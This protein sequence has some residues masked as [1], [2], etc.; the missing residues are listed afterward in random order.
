MA[1]YKETI[2]RFIIDGGHPGEAGFSA[3]GD[4][5]DITDYTPA[6]MRTFETKT[7][8]SGEMNLQS[9]WGWVISA[10]M[11]IF[12]S[13]GDMVG[14]I[15]CDFEAESVYQAVY[16][17]ILQQVIFVVVFMVIG[18]ILY[19]SLLK[20]ITRQNQKLIDMNKAFQAAS[21]SKS[22]FLARM[23]HEIRTP[24]NAIIGMNELAIRDYGHSEALEC[25]YDIRQAG[26]TLLSIIND[27]LDFSKIESGHIQ[28]TTARYDTAS[29]LNDALAIIRIRLCDKP[30]ELTA[31]ID[32][33]IPAFMTGDEVRVRQILLNILSNAEKY[34]NEGF[35]KF[36]ARW[37]KIG[38]ETVSLSFSVEDSGIGIKREDIGR[39][40]GDFSRVDL[41]RNKNIHD[42]QCFAVFGSSPDVS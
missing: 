36:T 12:N 31:D 20:A 17:R 35:I 9:S 4:E 30:I 1:P 3:L 25:L 34:T 23:S 7:V 13:A 24:M 42:G 38:D 33:S 2:H 28:I 15:G 27:I 6:Y 11:P 40:F 18:S 16:A 8:Q 21:E 37:E 5:E 32:P 29:L 19:F 22:V 39:L 10:Y 14:I 26:A 41:G